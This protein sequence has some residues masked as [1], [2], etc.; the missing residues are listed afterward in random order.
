LVSDHLSTPRF[1]Y[2]DKKTQTWR[3]ASDGFG[4]QAANDDVDGDGASVTL[5][6]RFPGQYYDQESGLHYNWNRYYD[7]D[8]GRYPTS[9]PIGL[10]GG[11][12]TYGYVRGNPLTRMDPDGLFDRGNYRI[13]N[14][15]K[16]LTGVLLLN[17]FG[18]GVLLGSGVGALAAMTPNN[19]NNVVPFPSDTPAGQCSE[20]DEDG[21]DG[22]F[23]WLLLLK[24][25]YDQISQMSRLSPGAH[26][27]ILKKQHNQ[28][29]DTFCEVCPELCSQAPRF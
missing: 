28:S 25:S 23:E 10:T 6:M 17:P 24:A 26:F 8:S 3:W 11:L 1:G 12:N 18:A 19:S 9:D 16:P 13:P 5:N 2:D 7:P 21:D 22:C 14:A 27:E 29:V 4:L 20:D 15:V